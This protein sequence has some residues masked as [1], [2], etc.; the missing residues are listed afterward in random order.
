MHRN[1]RDDPVLKSK[2]PMK[3]DDEDGESPS[4][5]FFRLDISFSCFIYLCHLAKVAKVLPEPGVVS[6]P[7]QAADKDLDEED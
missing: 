1:G 4:T 3:R 5:S 6:G 7:A 2:A